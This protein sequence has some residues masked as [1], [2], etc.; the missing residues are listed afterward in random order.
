MFRWKVFLPVLA[1]VIALGVFGVFYIDT[2]LKNQME[3]A[4]SSISGTKTDIESLRLSFKESSLKIKK[5]QIASSKEEF[6]N[7]MEFSD[8]IIDFQALPLLEKRFVVDEFS[9]TGIDWGTPRKTSGFLP[10]RKKQDQAEGPSWY[11]EWLDQSFDRVKEEFDELPVARLAD[12]RVPTDP[13]EILRTL[14]LKSEKALQQALVEVQDS[15]TKW[16]NEVK[17]LRDISEYKKQLKIAEN[18][19]KKLPEDPQKILAR[20]KTVKESI[21]FFEGEF[22][23]AESLLQDV[24]RQYDDLVKMYENASSA[25]EEDYNRARSLVSLDEFNLKNLS[26]LMFGEKWIDEAERVLYYHS[27]IRAKLAKVRVEEEKKVEVKQRAKGRDIIFVTPKKAPGFILAKSEFS[28]TGFEKDDGK[29]VRHTHE[30]N[31]RD[32]NS[33]P[34]IYEEPMEIAVSSRFKDFV[35][36]SI[37]F[38]ALLDYTQE[39]EKDEFELSAKKIK[40]SNWPVGIPKVFPVKIAEGNANSSSKLNFTGKEMKWVNRINFNKVK[41]DF[42]EVP[43]IGF[44]IPAI[45]DVMK[46]ISKFYLEIEFGRPEAGGLKFNVRSNLDKLMQEAISNIIDKKLDEFKAKLKREINRQVQKYKEEVEQ[47]LAEYRQQL[48]GEVKKKMRILKKYENQARRKVAELERKAKKAAEDQA[49]KLI[50]EKAGKE[51]KKLK[52]GARE[53]IKKNKPDIKLPF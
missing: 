49:K 14:D 13:D 42:R 53:Q 10:P 18:V 31:L 50:E 2:W 3:S 43:Q 7:L 26:K 47:Q 39:V 34:K 38:S 16:I 1:I 6:K 11:E 21:E 19:T 27:L 20:V 24:E 28:V 4:I 15:K 41:W 23:R 5:L 37:N 9:V 32:I 45:T 8:I 29:G 33:D 25:I 46:Q 51:A 40:A 12:Y 30:L 17:E 22:K 35:V 44:I 36:G 48:I 52:K